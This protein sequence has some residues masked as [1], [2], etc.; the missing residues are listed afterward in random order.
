MYGV[1]I[2][3]LLL[4]YERHMGQIREDKVLSIIHLSLRSIYTPQ[5]NNAVIINSS[6]LYDALF[7]RNI[8]RLLMHNQGVV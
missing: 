8:Q 3:I 6:L 7:W 1:Q 5:V 4:T 2:S